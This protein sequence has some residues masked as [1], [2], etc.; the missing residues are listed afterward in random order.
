M[1][2][3]NTNKICSRLSAFSESLFISLMF[4]LFQFNLGILGKKSPLKV[5]RCL[6]FRKI[7]KAPLEMIK[8]R[9]TGSPAVVHLK[10]NN[11]GGGTENPGMDQNPPSLLD[12]LCCART[13][14]KTQSTQTNATQRILSR[15]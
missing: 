3:T 13:E 1:K 9:R 5:K 6:L 10:T 14:K 15:G 11:L 2:T 8:P 12:K 4:I 7:P